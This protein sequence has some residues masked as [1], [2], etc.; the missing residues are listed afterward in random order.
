VFCVRYG[1]EGLCITPINLETQFYVF[2][3]KC[4]YVTKP[5]PFA[6]LYCSILLYSLQRFKE[7]SLL[8]SG[9]IVFCVSVLRI[10]FSVMIFDASTM[11]ATSSHK[12]HPFIG[13]FNST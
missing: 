13:L 6:T 2:L 7:L 10:D 5:L 8:R 1:P 4:M 9:L 12:C 11:N 3:N